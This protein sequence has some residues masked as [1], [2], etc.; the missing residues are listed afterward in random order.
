MSFY[1]TG[2]HNEIQ[3]C[4]SFLQY[5]VLIY[6]VYIGVSPSNCEANFK[7]TL[8]AAGCSISHETAARAR[9]KA[10]HLGHLQGNVIMTLMRQTDSSFIADQSC[11]FNVESSVIWKK[12]CFH[13]LLGALTFIMLIDESVIQSGNIMW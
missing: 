10:S 7:G 9:N 13:L 11:E 6:K 1:N 4:I 3:L 2:L 12:R 8:N 5:Q